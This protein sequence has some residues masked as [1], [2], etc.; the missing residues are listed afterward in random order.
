MTQKEIDQKLKEGGEM[1]KDFSFRKIIYYIIDI[2]CISHN[3]T[4]TQFNKAM[5]RHK[6]K[7][8]IYY[9]YGLQYTKLYLKYQKLTYDTKRQ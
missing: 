5:E 2:K 7:W 3:I 1:V 8:L 4:E 6:D 9:Y